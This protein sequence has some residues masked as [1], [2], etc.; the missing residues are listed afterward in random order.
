MGMISLATMLSWA[1]QHAIFP[2]HLADI[3]AGKKN[4]ILQLD[5]SRIYSI[6]VS[7]MV[8][9]PVQYFKNGSHDKL[10]LNTVFP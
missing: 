6:T 10:A 1:T 2:S 3:L 8:M 4:I 7:K 9:K 5:M